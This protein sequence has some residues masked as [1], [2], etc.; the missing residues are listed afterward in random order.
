MARQTHR[1]GEG[2][3]SRVHD[4]IFEAET[5]AGKAFD[6]L[7]I[8]AILSS[9][10]I[11]VLDSVE[12][13]NSK[14]HQVFFKLEWV[15]I[16]LFTAEYILRILT[17][18]SPW[19]YVRS[20]YG[21]IDLL[22]VIPTY[23][24]LLL[25]GS[26]AMIILRALRLLRIFRILKLV[27]YLGAERHLLTAFR[28]SVP[29]ITIF[30]VAVCCIVLISGTLM[31]NIEGKENGFTSIPVGIYWAVVTLT[32]VGYGDISPVTPL[33]QFIS[34]IIMIMGY[35]II[36]VPTGIVPAEITRLSLEK[37]STR[38]CHNCGKEDHDSDAVY[39]KYCGDK[40]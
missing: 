11:V 28:A 24:G 13:I 40:I 27:R 1:Y 39:C 19:Y 10:T 29:K 18:R 17:L 14:Y 38:T 4:I 6:I 12:S 36:A 20:F 32:T 37:P 7:L 8:I 5:P 9:V 25:T 26:S 23:L 2:W 30:L 15:F 33:G 35:G 3:R 34:M 31:Y 16:I 22:A 21:V